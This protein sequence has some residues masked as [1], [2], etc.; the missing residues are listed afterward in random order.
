MDSVVKKYVCIIG[1]GSIGVRHGKIFEKIG[2]NVTYFRQKK[3]S[4]LQ[5]NE[6]KNI[7]DLKKKIDLICICNPTSLHSRTFIQ[8]QDISKNFFIEKPSFNKA[9]D[10]K[11]IFRIIKKK[12]I[13]IFSGYMFRFDPRILLIK[14]IIKKSKIRYANF[15]WQTFMPNWHPW[16]NYKN[17]YASIKKL[18]GGVLLTCSHEIDMAQNLFGK[19]NKVFCTDTISNLG[20]NVENSVFLILIHKNGIKS[21]ITIDFSSKQSQRIFEISGN[22]L[23]IIWNFKNKKVLIKKKNKIY[24]KKPRVDSNINK[25]Y[26]YQNKMHL[27]NLYKKQNKNLNSLFHTEK[28]ILTALKSMRSKKIE[29]LK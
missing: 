2:C 6:I 18:G 14:S 9:S 15:I 29:I 26:L 13:N 4:S 8:F 17:S 22:D 28:I 11:K 5:K 20:T 27:K 12:K 16:E 3:S 25:I 1:K 10:I 19:V 21:N 23:N 24:F 7:K